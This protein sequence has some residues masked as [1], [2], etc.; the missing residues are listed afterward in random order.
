M[1]KWSS[2]NWKCRWGRTP[3][4]AVMWGSKELIRKWEPLRPVAYLD[5]IIFYRH[6]QLCCLLETVWDLPAMDRGQPEVVPSPPSVSPRRK[7][8]EYLKP[9]KGTKNV[10]SFLLGRQL[11]RHEDEAEMSKRLW[12]L[13]RGM[14]GWRWPLPKHHI[15]YM[16]MPTPNHGKPSKKNG[17]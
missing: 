2:G 17:K 14:P 10:M 6:P 4:L 7:A 12:M 9:G 15:T 13:T 5:F 3:A 11:G 1:S 8:D 16:L